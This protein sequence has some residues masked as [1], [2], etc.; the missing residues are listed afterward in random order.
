[1]NRY[2]L[3][4]ILD[5]KLEETARKDLIARFST[6]LTDNGAEIEKVEE[7]GKRRLAYLINDEP[8]GYYVQIMFKAGSEVPREIERNLEISESVL[9]YLIV[10]QLEKRASVKPRPVRIAP[11]PMQAAPVASEA[12][13]ASV[14]QEAPAAEEAPAVEAATEAPVAEAPAATE[15]E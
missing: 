1:M 13:A 6:L 4:Y 3:I 14:A 8:E 2:E 9:R 12:P 7:W 15:A 5:A 11:I 10:K